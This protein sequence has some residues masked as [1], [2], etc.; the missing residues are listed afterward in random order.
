MGEGV[1][2]TDV[3]AEEEERLWRAVTKWEEE[4]EEERLEFE[5]EEE[6]EEVE[7][8]RYGLWRRRG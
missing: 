2:D 5:D 8:G 1:R 7:F 4:E 3:E 6:D